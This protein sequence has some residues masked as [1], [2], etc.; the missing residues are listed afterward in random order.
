MLIIING[1]KINANVEKVNEEIKEFQVG[2]EVTGENN[3]NLYSTLLKN[4]KVRVKLPDINLEYESKIT[5]LVSSHKGNLNEN[6][7]VYFSFKISEIVDE[8]KEWTMFDGLFHTAIHNWTR[9]RALAKILENNNLLTKEEYE[10][11]ID[12]IG[13]SDFEEMKK[14]ILEG[15]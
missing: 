5:N 7:I 13:E 6:T 3:F 12:E 15:K 1:V 4:D 10:K 9:T 14:Y 8:E 2:F 11:L